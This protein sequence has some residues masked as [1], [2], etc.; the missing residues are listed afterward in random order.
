MR[1]WGVVLFVLAC[2][3]FAGDAPEVVYG[4]FHRAIA[5]GNL[6][7]TMRYAPAARRAEVASM[8]PSEKEAQV[9][10]MTMMLPKAFRLLNK[11]IAQDGKS[12]RLLVTGP[13]AALAGG[14]M[15]PMYGTVKMVMENG[16]WK[17]DELSWSG[18]KP[19]AAE[20]A[21]AGSAPSA[22]PSASPKAPV[23]PPAPR[24][25]LGKAKPECVF[26]PV[27]SNE[28]LERCR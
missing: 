19:S 17:V 1:L 9:K 22:A 2:R 7:E 5:S 25:V 12:A 28:D 15:E 13:G 11:R 4:R 10:M 23:A 14:K 6:E 26:K 24:H 18:D 20:L 3:A 16:E 8:S 27:M 21:P